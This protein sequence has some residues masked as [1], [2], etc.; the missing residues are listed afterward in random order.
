MPLCS[1]LLAIEKNIV[2]LMFQEF[3]KFVNIVFKSFIR[4]PK[5]REMKVLMTKFK[6][7]CQ[8]L[9]MQVAIDGTHVHIS[10]PKTPFIKD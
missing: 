8:L 1:K 5:G 2:A 3:V 7:W 9:S 6:P 4:W 10:K